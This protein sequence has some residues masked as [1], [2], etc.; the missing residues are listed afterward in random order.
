MDLNSIVGTGKTTL[1]TKMI[2]ERK[3]LQ[4]TGAIGKHA[5]LFNKTEKIVEENLPTEAEVQAKQKLFTRVREIITAIFPGSVVQKYGWSSTA[6]DIK[7][8]ALD[9][10]VLTSEHGCKTDAAT[11]LRRIQKD[12]Q[13]VEDLANQFQEHHMDEFLFCIPELNVP[14][15][16]LRLQSNNHST[17]S[18][19]VTVTLFIIITAH[20]ECHSLTSL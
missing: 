13:K 6:F 18:V 20:T 15:P 3:R 2:N 11:M 16:M 14:V 8:S 7:G 19:A 12:R 4:D 9:V 5:L 10:V 1:I 17:I